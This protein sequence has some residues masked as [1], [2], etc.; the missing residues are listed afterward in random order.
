MKTMRSEIKRFRIFDEQT[1]ELS[2]EY[3]IFIGRKKK[4]YDVG[5]VKIFTA[6]LEDIVEDEKLAGKA[7]RLL[8]YMLKKLQYNSFRIPIDP[9]EV[10]KELNI[11]R[12]TYQ[13]WIKDLI[14]AGIITKINPYLYEI[15]ANIAFKGKHNE[16]I[17]KEID[18]KIS[19]V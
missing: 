19:E 3:A 8:F 6:F 4:T 17:E 12:D 18:K 16:T 15:N 14:E 11:S 13:R 5:Y 7:I 2:E 9:K 10:Q 1:G